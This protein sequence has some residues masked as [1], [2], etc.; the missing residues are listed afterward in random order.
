MKHGWAPLYILA[1]GSLWGTT[2]IFVRHFQVLGLGS[3]EIGLLRVAMGLLIVGVYL[4]L[5]HKDLLRIRVRD[6]WC[7]CGTGIASLFLMNLTYFSAMQHTS[8]AVAGVLLYTAPVFVMLLSALLFREVITGRKVL[9]LALAFLGCVLV[10]GL[11]SSDSVAPLGLCLGL[12]AGLSYALYSIF[13]RYAI[14]RGYRSWTITFYS[15]LLCTLASLLCCDK[16][17]VVSVIFRSSQWIWIVLL[18]F[19]TSFMPYIFY[20]KGLEKI[21]NSRASI[22]ASIE[23]VV[24]AVISVC[25][26]QEPI[27]WMAV[28]GILSVLAAII[29]LSVRSG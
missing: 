14:M 27:S 17:A 21:E 23:P 20:S 13:G 7:F 16:T 15:F 18:G 9:S 25:I 2:G 8:L 1:A 22:L 11:G 6:L 26:F 5:F 28:L 3:M 24:A 29:F 12:G 19:V 4:L 10:S